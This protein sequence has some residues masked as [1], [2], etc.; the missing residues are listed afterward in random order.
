MKLVLVPVI[1]LLTLLGCSGPA[2]DDE[3]RP[4]EETV[5]DDQIQA[6]DRA[7]DV[8]DQLKDSADDRRRAL[9]E[10]ER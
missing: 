9:E 5:F 2:D 4:V 8:E 1:A 10:Q 7:R 3:V 6:M